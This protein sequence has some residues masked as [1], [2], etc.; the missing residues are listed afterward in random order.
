[1][2]VLL[3]PVRCYR[4]L[5]RQAQSQCKSRTALR[6]N[7][8]ASPLDDAGLRLGNDHL[9]DGL[10]VLGCLRSESEV[11]ALGIGTC[12]F[13]RIVDEMTVGPR[14]ASRRHTGDVETDHPHAGRRADH[15][16]AV[17]LP[18]LHPGSPPGQAAVQ[19]TDRT[20]PTLV[21]QADQSP[22]RFRDRMARSASRLSVFSRRAWRLSNS[23][24]PFATAISTLARPSEK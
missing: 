6:R 10:H 9:A 2:F 7:R 24:L 19:S 20:A 12:C 13:P 5:G 1:M 17:E 3:G 14:P 18:S 11:S 21:E 22:R 16:H 15:C 23:R 4:L 8:A